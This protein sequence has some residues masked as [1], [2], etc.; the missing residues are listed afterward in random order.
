VKYRLSTKSVR[1]VATFEARYDRS[2]GDEGGFYA[3]VNDDLGPGQPLILLG[4]L[5]S[6]DR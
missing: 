4:L 1:L 3:G 5:C 2:T 6:F